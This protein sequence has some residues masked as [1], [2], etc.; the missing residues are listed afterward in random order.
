[1]AAYLLPFFKLDFKQFVDGF[2]VIECVHDRQVDHSPKVYEI[3]L[4]PI[5]DAFLGF[6]N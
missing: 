1:M 4:C 6:R 2:F 5:L 3:C